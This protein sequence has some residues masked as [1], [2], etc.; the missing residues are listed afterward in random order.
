AWDAGSLGELWGCGQVRGGGRRVSAHAE[1]WSVGSRGAAEGA[2]SV[3]R[4]GRVLGGAERSSPGSTF[5]LNVVYSGG[6]R[7]HPAAQPAGRGWLHPANADPPDANHESPDHA[8]QP[9]QRQRPRST[10]PQP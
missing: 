5:M 4:P 8:A 1:A 3:A 2:G 7:D 9:P 10:P 6:I